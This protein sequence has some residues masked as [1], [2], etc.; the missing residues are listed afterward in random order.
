MDSCSNFRTVSQTI[1]EEWLTTDIRFSYKE[2]KSSQ[3]RYLSERV[4]DD[5]WL[6]HYQP[7]HPSFEAN[8]SVNYQMN[9]LRLLPAATSDRFCEANDLYSALCAVVDK[10]YD[11]IDAD[12]DGE[13]KCLK[14][15]HA[16]QSDD[17]SPL[18]EAQRE[19]CIKAYLC[20][21]LVSRLR[22]SVDI[23]AVTGGSIEPPASE[24]LDDDF[25]AT[26]AVHSINER[27]LEDIALFT[28]EAGFFGDRYG[29]SGL[30]LEKLLVSDQEPDYLLNDVAFV[31]EGNP[32]PGTEPPKL[33]IIAESIDHKSRASWF[34]IEDPADRYEEIWG[35]L[36]KMTEADS[37]IDEEAIFSERVDWRIIT[38][39]RCQ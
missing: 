21:K 32:W 11:V 17:Y 14:D 26:I 2:W 15:R 3:N 38:G 27:L 29:D 4:A 28:V 22:G 13:L 7:I 34:R 8:H 36:N 18:N 39:L 10:L 24:P 6:Q 31:Y 19:Q 20:A 23:E 9:W 35:D 1:L 5:D 25:E 33:P 16:E 12:V 37:G 30:M